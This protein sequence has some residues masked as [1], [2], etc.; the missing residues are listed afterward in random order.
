MSDMQNNDPKPRKKPASGAGQLVPFPTSGPNRTGLERLP[1]DMIITIDGQARTG[2]NTVGELLAGALGG[3]L[4]DSGRFYRSIT[5]AALMAGVELDDPDAIE[6]FCGGSRVDAILRPNERGVLEA[7]ATV[8]GGLFAESTLVAVGKLVPQVAQVPLVRVLVNA[9]L[10]RIF[11]GGRMI[12]LG[13]DIGMKVFPYTPYQF[14]FRAPASV[15]EL[16]DSGRA[17]GDA[18]M[19]RDRDDARQTFV[20]PRAAQVET[21]DKTPEQVL[22][23]L[24]DEIL[25][26]TPE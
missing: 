10:R 24:L 2:K 19:R 23:I 6:S 25:L 12:V 16:R 17:D 20:S 9:T 1:R 5:Q 8:N 15:R 22:A 3:V 7:L 11:R 21:G 4:V 14:Y 18:V 26:R 13:R